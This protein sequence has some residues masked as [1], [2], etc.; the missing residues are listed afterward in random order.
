MVINAVSFLPYRLSNF[1]DLLP[2]YYRSWETNFI[3]KNK[4]RLLK[5]IEKKYKRGAKKISHSDGLKMEF[6]NYW[7]NVRPSNTEPL[8]RLNI[9]AKTEKLLQAKLKELKKIISS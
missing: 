2:H 6:D 8:L 5:I 4:E 7:L 3:V 9:E 1:V